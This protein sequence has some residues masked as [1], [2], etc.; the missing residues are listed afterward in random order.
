MSTEATPLLVERDE[1]STPPSRWRFQVQRPRTIA[2]LLSLL[3]LILSTATNLMLVPTTRIL[4]DI[5]CH[6][7]YEV[8][9]KSE[10]IDE[11]LCKIDAIQSELAYL[12]GIISTME[13]IVG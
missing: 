5:I 11:R 4:E 10:V 1:D 3:I 7:H 6:H 8:Q 9:G 12:N 2:V 13:A